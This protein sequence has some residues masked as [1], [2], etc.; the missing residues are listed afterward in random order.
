LAWCERAGASAPQ[1]GNRAVPGHVSALTCF[2]C[3]WPGCGDGFLPGVL[4]IAPVE[5]IRHASERPIVWRIAIA[6]PPFAG[7]SP[8]AGNSDP[9]AMP[10]VLDERGSADRCLPGLSPTNRAGQVG[11]CEAKQ[12]KTGLSTPPFFFLRRWQLAAVLR[13]QLLC[14]SNYHRCSSEKG[15]RYFDL[16][17]LSAVV[18]TRAVPV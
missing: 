6:L 1:D 18:K 16:N 15:E 12:A 9:A 11:T 17:S 10:I 7:H 13:P 4:A 14:L 3:S 5:I 2:P 8:A